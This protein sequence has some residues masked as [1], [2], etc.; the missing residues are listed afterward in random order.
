MSGMLST[1]RAKG[2]VD[3]RW[4]VL[5]IVLLPLLPL[6]LFVK[7]RLDLKW[8]LGLCALALLPGLVGAMVEPPAEPV[9]KDRGVQERSSS[10]STSSPSSSD[11][12]S[13][14]ATATA[15]PSGEIVAFVGS[16]DNAG[17]EQAAAEA[18]AAAKALADKAAK[19]KAAKDKAAKAAA[20]RQQAAAA[21]R[22][23]AQKA[24]QEKAAQKKAAQKKAAAARAKR[25]QAA[26]AKAAAASD[27]LFGTCGEANDAGYGNYHAGVDPEYSNYQ[28]RDGDGVVCEF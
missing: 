26:A 7:G 22:A 16:A 17:S 12:P 23:A 3:W 11:S 18:S 21:K 10:P 28:D 4:V 19:D 27:P 2:S 13:Q 25:E 5:F 14:A 9:A 24:A 1:R 6:Y 20:A 8:A 15:T